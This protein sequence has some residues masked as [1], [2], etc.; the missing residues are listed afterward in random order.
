M[1]G[2]LEVSLS[3]TLEPFAAK[4]INKKEAAISSLFKCTE[5]KPT[6]FV[7]NGCVM[8]CLNSHFCYR[9]ITIH[10]S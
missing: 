8:L 9:T 7:C 1:Q 4:K 6:I 5:L 2:P 10:E 3:W